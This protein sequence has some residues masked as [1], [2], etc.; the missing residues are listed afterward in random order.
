MLT[1]EDL[2]HR[3]ETIADSPSLRALRSRLG[4][5]AERLLT[6]DLRFPDQ[7][8]LLSVDGGVCPGDGAA[9]RFDPWSP[10]RHTCPRCGEIHQG[11]RHDRWWARFQHLWLAERSVHLASLAVLGE[12]QAAHRARD[13]LSWYAE[14]YHAFPNRDNVLGPS[15]LFFSTYLESIWLSHMLLAAWLLRVGGL[16]EGGLGERVSGMADDAANLIG[17][18]DE[19][20]SNRQTW[21][22]AALAAVAVWFEDEA[23]AHRVIEGPTGLIAHLI[24]GFGDDGLWYE[25]ENYHFFAWQGLLY[26]SGWTRL[27]GVDFFQ[28]PELVPRMQR[29]LT[30]P[31]ATALPDGTFPARKDSRFG[32]SLAQP[33]YLDAWETTLA[34]LQ[35]AGGEDAEA[36]GWLAHLYDLPAQ[37]ALLADSYLDEVDQ[38]APEVRSRAD[39]SWRALLEALPEL[40]DEPYPDPPSQLL[41]SQ[42][43]AILRH[44]ERYVGLECGPYGGGHG[45]PDRLHLTLA[46]DGVLWLP[47]PGTGS[48]VEGDLHWYR[49][50]LA[51]NAPMLDGVSQAPGDATCRAFDESEGWRWVSGVYGDLARTVVDGPDHVVDLVESTYGEPHALDVPWHVQGE[52]TTLSPGEW[53]SV[54][55]GFPHITA[56]ERFHPAG[57][58]PILVRWRIGEANLTAAFA[59]SGEL[60]CLTGP[61]LPGAVDPATFLLAR[62]QGA[63]LRA[64]T[65]LV[66]GTD[67]DRLQLNVD[68]DQITVRVGETSAVHQVVTGGWQ[69]QAGGARARLEGVRPPPPRARPLIY[70][71]PPLT[72]SAMIPW[73]A[74]HPGHDGEGASVES[75]EL[76]LD[77]E[78]QYRRSEEPYPGAEALSALARVGWNDEGLFLDVAVRKPEIVPWSADAPPLL[79]DNE[80]DDIHNDGV[81][82]YLSFEE[83]EVFSA[84]IAPS[85]PVPGIHV[86]SIAGNGTVEG[87]WETTS[88]GYRISVSLRP[89]W[90]GTLA[91]GARVGFD[92]IVNEARPERVRRAGQLVWSGGGGWVWLRGDREAPDGFGTLVLG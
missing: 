55:C 92:L 18:F 58:D 4:Q 47:D 60:W 22:N 41:E 56:A 5:R 63:H 64:V 50:T 48:Y 32:V 69:V 11:D 61:G 72:V 9:L 21:H 3:N 39:L 15:R 68:G 91:E 59:F 25:G 62:M 10:D 20:F 78:D 30:G 76:H 83:R 80:S 27:A 45:H 70:R 38:P 65:L 42:G 89:E 6:D 31:I 88:D 23:L 35:E 13:I 82:I 46:A 86:R 79:L 87:T 44:E 17:E 29:I 71:E 12:V 51:H 73:V 53:R 52:M 90:W 24:H 66:P 81:Q 74:T 8:A 34:R 33:M 26:G 57:D 43:V 28:E 77:H 37:P 2:A 36:A 85:E 16:L 67:A 19:G 1:A 7:K 14:R 75:A 40:P 84:L 54:P 49:S